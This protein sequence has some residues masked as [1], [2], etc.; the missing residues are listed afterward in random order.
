[1][2]LLVSVSNEAEACAAREGGADIIDAKDPHA[3]ALGGPVSAALGDAD[4]EDAIE[5]MARD[6]TSAGATFVKVGFAGIEDASLVRSLLR[7]AVRGASDAHGHVVAVAYADAMSTLTLDEVLDAASS[8]GA[9]GVLVDTADKSGPGLR[10]LIDGDTLARWISRAHDAG[11]TVAVAGKLVLDDLEWARD[12]GA[13]IAGVRG[14]ACQS[15]RASRVLAEK[16]RL[17]RAAA[18]PLVAPRISYR[19]RAR[20]WSFVRGS[21]S[22]LWSKVLGPW[23]GRCHVRGKAA[24]PR[25]KDSPGPGTTDQGRQLHGNE[26]C[27]R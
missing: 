19:C 12:R 10:S 21:W 5:R 22:V 7:A 15:G 8:A 20:P 26:N 3:G 27:S 14:A 18:A 17:L 11:L 6:Y 24:D 23:S 16:I 4:R 9:S 13:D 25:S 2:Q 1:M